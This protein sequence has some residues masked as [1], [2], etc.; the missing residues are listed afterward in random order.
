MYVK[1]MSLFCLILLSGVAFG[2]KSMTDSTY[3][4]KEV[5]VRSNQLQDFAIGSSIQKVD[6]LSKMVFLSQSLAELLSAKSQLFIKS[7]GP[8]GVANPSIRGGAASHT[9]VIWNGVNIQS[10]MDGGV[11]FTLLPNFLF[12]DLTIQ[13]G[14][15]GTLYG[16]GAVSGVLH[17]SNGDLFRTQNKLKLGSSFGSFGQASYYGGVKLGSNKLANYFRFYSNTADNDFEYKKADGIKTKQ[18]HAHLEQQAF[19]NET[20]LRTSKNSI[21]KATFWYQTYDKEIQTTISATKPSEAI[22]EDENWRMAL[23][24]QRTGKQFL[25]TLKSV[26]LQNEIYYFDPSYM[27]EGTLNLSKSWINE[28]TSKYILNKNQ[29]IIGGVNYTHEKAESGSYAAEVS[30][31]RLSLFLSH[32][33]KNLLDNRMTIVNSIRQEWVEGHNSPMVF[34]SGVNVKMNPFIN[35]NGNIS[36]TYKNPSLNSLYWS[37]AWSVG[38]PDLKAE[39]GWSLDLGFDETFTISDVKLRLKQN[40]FLNNIKDWIV[41]LPN[42]TFTIWSPVNKDKGKTLG[43]DFNLDAEFKLGSTTINFLGAYTWTDSKFIEI[44]GGE[45][46]EKDMLYVPEHRLNI[47]LRATGKRW[48]LMY[49]HNFVDSRLPDHWGGKMESY[50]LGDLSFN[51]NF[52]GGIQGLSTSI[53]IHNLWAKN[54]QVMNDYAMPG[55]YLKFS[56]QYSLNFKK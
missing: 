15:S 54:Y 33:F 55:R 26:Y 44:V 11:N 25:T 39:K 8:G 35:F 17:L 20:Q 28:A 23:N 7:Y 9:A 29:V 24:W 30:Q 37:D 41:W 5:V 18:S 31:N 43:L 47:S 22:Q 19:V 46:V 38:N 3:L 56:L 2:Q 32:K 40:F 42:E 50:D 10:P 12:D 16:S 14:G 13:Y 45:E 53:Q 34:S 52:F 48:G 6:S 27:S 1:K 51:Y 49:S 21:L 36:R 4:M